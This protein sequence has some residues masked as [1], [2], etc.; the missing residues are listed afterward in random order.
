M[1]FEEPPYPTPEKYLDL[2]Y[3]RPAHQELGIIGGR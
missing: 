3:L 2:S 1:E